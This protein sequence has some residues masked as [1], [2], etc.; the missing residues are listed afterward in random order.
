MSSDLLPATRRLL[1]LGGGGLLGQAVA[2][3]A[4]DRGWSC[5]APT[6]TQLDLTT[7]AAVERE[8]V[9]SSEGG[10]GNGLDV[11]INCA[12]YTK[13]DAAE[14]HQD[15]AMEINGHA[16]GRLANLCRD[17]GVRLV[18][19]SSDYVFP[20]EATEPY[21][22]DDALGPRSIYGRSKA[23]GE[24]L[25][26]DSGADVVR[27]SWLFGPGAS[28]FVATMLRLAQKSGP[29]EVVDDQIGRPTYAPFLA[30]ALLE[31]VTLGTRP[32]LLHYANPPSTSWHG[33]AQVIFEVFEKTVDLNPCRSSE[34]ARPAPRPAYSVL[35]TERIEQLLGRS[36]PTW[37]EGLE[38]YRRRLDAEREPVSA[39]HQSAR[40]RPTGDLASNSGE[41][42]E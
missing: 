29:L 41:R 5:R 30:E 28:N 2:R 14:T 32:A 6:R 24:R 35:G 3:A 36:L 13:V 16:V 21:R 33:F 25:A 15:E 4:A 12:A 18:H 40:A 22:E 17:R 23:L 19:I 7:T 11:V 9:A 20:G 34:S 38:D 37:R 26:L 8:L 39:G 42:G 10:G 1:V 31:V 27:A